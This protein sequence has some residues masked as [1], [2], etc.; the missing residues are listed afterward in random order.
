MYSRKPLRLRGFEYSS[1]NLYL[2]TACTFERRCL[3]G[4]IDAESFV[5][6]GFGEV[7]RRQVELLPCRLAGV[8][9]DAFVVMPN[10][11]HAIV[12]LTRARQAS[13][14]RLGSVVGSLKSGGAR[15]INALRGTP[16]A[17]VWQRGY[18]DHVIRDESDLRRVR[19]YVESNPI[20]WA[21]DLENP[22]RSS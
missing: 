2:V 13:P 14:L 15:E 8:H 4:S 22:A 20:R 3:L 16:G 17:N 18:H 11:L 5:P 12:A 6:S 1:E 7:V 10:H 19:E 9:V 21:F